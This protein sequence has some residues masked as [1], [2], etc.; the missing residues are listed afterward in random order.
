MELPTLEGLTPEAR[1]RLTLIAMLIDGK[2]ATPKAEEAKK[3]EGWCAP[4]GGDKLTIIGN[5][6]GHCFSVGDVVLVDYCTGIY[7]SVTSKNE[8]AVYCRNENKGTTSNV[9]LCDV[10]R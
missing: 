8:V 7:S 4:S 10:K 5:V 6:S 3:E 9:L 2:P 1:E